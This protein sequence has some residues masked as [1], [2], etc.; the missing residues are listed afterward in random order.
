[1]ENSALRKTFVLFPFCLSF[2]SKF[3]IEKG[4]RRM[5]ILFGGM[6]MEEYGAGY[7]YFS[8]YGCHLFWM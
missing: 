8:F 5:G 7:L 6:E 2:P 4:P 3:V 1:M